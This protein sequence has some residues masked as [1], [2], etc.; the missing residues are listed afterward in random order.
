VEIVASQGYD[1]IYEL[2]DKSITAFRL[3][4]T[5][6]V[7]DAYLYAGEKNNVEYYILLSPINGEIET[8]IMGNGN[9]LDKYFEMKY[10]Q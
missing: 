9:Y 1:N 6:L 10:G 8:E 3:K 4:H 7:P 5:H 2:K